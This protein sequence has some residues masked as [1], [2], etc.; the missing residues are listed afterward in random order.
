LGSSQDEKGEAQFPYLKIEAIELHLL[1]ETQAIPYPYYYRPRWYGYDPW[2]WNNP[3]YW[4]GGYWG[5][6]GS[7]YM[8]YF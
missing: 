7:W 3:L 6:H 1:P 4:G 2:Y 5:V 8:R